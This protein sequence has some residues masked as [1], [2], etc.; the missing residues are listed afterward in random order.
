V[1]S[2]S[3]VGQDGEY[4]AVAVGLGEVE[5]GED[6][7]DVFGHRGVADS[8]RSGDGRVVVAFGHLP[9]HLPF[10]CGQPVEWV[11]R[12]SAVQQPTEAP[13][14]V[15]SAFGGPTQRPT[16]PVR[17]PAHDTFRRLLRRVNATTVDTAIGLFLAERAGFSGL[18]HHRRADTVPGDGGQT[19]DDEAFHDVSIA[20]ALA[21]DG[22]AQRGARQADGRAVHLLATM[23]HQTGAVVAQRDVHHKTN[24]IRQVKPP[25]DP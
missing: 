24:E 16:R 4:P 22:E 9:E 6:V 11:G 3:Q 7:A 23:T 14:P 8:E 5:F 2:A 13:Q 12:A 19:D 18:Y 15:L 1:R 25:L 17:G 10:P 20:G 21:V